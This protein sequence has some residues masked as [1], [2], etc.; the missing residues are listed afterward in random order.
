VNPH[1]ERVRVFEEQ[2]ASLKSSRTAKDPRVFVDAKIVSR[3]DK[4]APKR[5]V[6]GFV[7]QG[8]QDYENARFLEADETDDAELNAVY[9]AIQQLKDKLPEF[10][11]ICDHDS[12]VSMIDRGSPKM[13]RKRPILSK[14]LGEKEKYPG[15]E[16]V[17]LEKNPAHKF[18]NKWYANHISSK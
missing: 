13:V 7:L 14:I 9:F 2:L 6:V 17:G 1:E 5:T 16:V 4:D 18:L 3:H 15:I 8:G 12:V 11:I 10:T